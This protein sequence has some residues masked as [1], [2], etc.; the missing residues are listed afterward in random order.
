VSEREIAIL[1][2]LEE[3]QIDGLL[4][5]SS[6]LDDQELG[7]MLQRFPSV[8]LISRQFSIA[9]VGMLLIDDQM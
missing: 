7:Q 1:E 3:K 5:C 2:S 8:V 9:N 6:R 4:L